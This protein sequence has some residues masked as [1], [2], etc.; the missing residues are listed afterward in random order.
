MKRWARSVWGWHGRRCRTAAGLNW[1]TVRSHGWRSVWLTYQWAKDWDLSSV[2]GNCE[3]AEVLGVELRTTHAHGVEPTLSRQ[4]RQEVQR[5]FADSPVELVGLGSDERF[6]NPDPDA[7]RQAIAKVKEF[8]QLSHDVGGTGVK[9]KPDTL[10]PDVPRGKTIEQ[11]GRALNEVAEYG[12]GY[13]Q[14]VRLEVH[15]KCAELPTIK[16]IM[17]VADHDNACHLLE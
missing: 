12:A 13:G 9:V 6:D 4:Q 17:E 1:D 8:I 10:H 11:I 15:G 16:A 5:R 7:L 3:K 2:I 14:Q